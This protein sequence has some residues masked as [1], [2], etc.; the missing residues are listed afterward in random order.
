MKTFY[1]STFMKNEELNSAGI[2]YP[3]KLEYYKIINEDVILETTKAKFG[4]NVIKTEYKKEKTEIEDK[5]IQYISNDEKQIE[6]I[7]TIFKDNKVTP[8]IVEDVLNDIYK[9]WILI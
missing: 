5:K 1:S 9:K 4:I 3:I 2:E 6:E 8:I 7:L